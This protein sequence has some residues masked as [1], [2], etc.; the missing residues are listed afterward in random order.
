MIFPGERNYDLKS[1]FKDGSKN[2]FLLRPKGL[3]TFDTSC[4]IYTV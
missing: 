2:K 1:L 3:C 4:Y